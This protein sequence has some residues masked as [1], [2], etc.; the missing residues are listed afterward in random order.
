[1]GL[2]NSAPLGFGWLICSGSAYCEYAMPTLSTRR[3][4]SDRGYCLPRFDVFGRLMR[5]AL[6]YAVAPFL[7]S[8]CLFWVGRVYVSYS[9]VVTHVLEDIITLD[10]YP[11]IGR[12]L[13]CSTALM[14]RVHV[15]I[16]G[17]C[18]PTPF[19]SSLASW[20][21]HMLLGVLF[22][23]LYVFLSHEKG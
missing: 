7:Y 20:F 4:S 21:R 18:F 15:I 5:F 2:S 9:F 11:Y 8:A 10:C 23:C 14:T 17:V 19:S 16:V 13:R 22:L 1:M 6:I 3:M 12:M